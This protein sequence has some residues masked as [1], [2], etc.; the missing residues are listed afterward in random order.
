MKTSTLKQKTPLKRKTGLQARS[1]FKRSTTPLRA[2]TGL[3]R[4]KTLKRSSDSDMI[5]LDRIFSEV[6]RRKAADSSGR[7]SC[8]TCGTI[9]HWRLMQAGHF[10]DRQHLA[11]RY[12]ETNVF[13]QDEDC[14]CF[15]D[16]KEMLAKY[17][18]FL[19]AKFGPNHP[20]LLKQK[21]QQI[22]HA[23]PFKELIAKY[24]DELNQ[25]RDY[26]DSEIQL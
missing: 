3:K 15:M 2:I 18:D 14:N 21:A 9:L 12:D 10:Q 4:G 13:C 5:V 26:Q 1:G 6:V 20:D 19:R 11:T 8:V 23:F 16:K 24:T 17:E 7:V 25:L 22:T